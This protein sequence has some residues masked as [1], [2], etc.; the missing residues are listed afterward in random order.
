MAHFGEENKTLFAQD[1]LYL[2]VLIRLVLIPA[3]LLY[4]A[5]RY[6]LSHAVQE[7]ATKR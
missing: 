4:L 6:L 1:N 5:H 7:G 3:V 2:E